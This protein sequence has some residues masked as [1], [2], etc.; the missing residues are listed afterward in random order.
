VANYGDRA[1]CKQFSVLAEARAATVRLSGGQLQIKTLRM[2]LQ[3]G[4][5]WS[6][7]QAGSRA[8]RP[9]SWR[10]GCG[11]ARC[12]SCE[13]RRRRPLADHPSSPGLQPTVKGGHAA[14]AAHS[15]MALLEQLC[16]ALRA[17]LAEGGVRARTRSAHAWLRHRA[18]MAA[19]VSGS[20]QA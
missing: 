9:A 17:R 12:S 1:Q 15:T 11:Q 18:L 13:R 20:K 6:C 4:G 14:C 3:M 10:V 8:A 16:T 5:A 7:S 19:A 2:R